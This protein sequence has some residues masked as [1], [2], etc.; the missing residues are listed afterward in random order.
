[1]LFQ[2]AR[3]TC[4]HNFA[5]QTIHRPAEAQSTSLGVYGLGSV[6]YGEIKG[7]VPSTSLCFFTL[8]RA[9]SLS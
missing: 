6:A 5:F 4:A 2:R 8:S 1:M 7:P 9:L 3:F